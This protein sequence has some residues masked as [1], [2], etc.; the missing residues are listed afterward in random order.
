MLNTRHI[1]ALGGVSALLFAFAPAAMATPSP[2]GTDNV[3]GGVTGGS[4]S[5]TVGADGGSIGSPAWSVTLG[6]TNG[7]GGNQ[8]AAYVQNINPSNDLGTGQAWTDTVSATS[9]VGVSG[10]AQAHAFK[11]GASGDSSITGATDET[12]TLGA[13]PIT[14]VTGGSSGNDSFLGTAASATTVIPQGSGTGL[15]AASFLN[16]DTGQGMGDFTLAPIVT[17][18]VPADAYAGTYESTVTYTVQTGPT[19][20]GSLGAT[21]A[22]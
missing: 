18:V 16:A 20:P 13:A 6:G 21:P 10:A 2:T 5:Q 19:Q 4:L 9:Y 12:S 8:T 11:F 22:L 3:F 7:G 1:M 14:S 17:V 15:T